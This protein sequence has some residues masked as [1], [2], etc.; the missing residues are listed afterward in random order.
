MLLPLQRWVGAPRW[1]DRTGA[2]LEGSA[3][4]LAT[5]STL[6]DI[7]SR[8]AGWYTAQMRSGSGQQLVVIRMYMRCTAC[9]DA[10]QSR[11]RRGRIPPL[12]VARADSSRRRSA[13]LCLYP[14]CVRPPRSSPCCMGDMQCQFN[15]LPWGGGRRAAIRPQGRTRIRRFPSRSKNADQQRKSEENITT[16]D[17]KKSTANDIHEYVYGPHLH[18]LC[19]VSSRR[20]ST[21]RVASL[22]RTS[23]LAHPS[24]AAAHLRT[25][26]SAP[27]S[28]SSTLSSPPFL[29]LSPC[30]A[31]RRLRTR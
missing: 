20:R 25:S 4:R 27:P 3:A 16:Y 22:H 15:V 21:R 8:E 12:L 17:N 10:R 14:R 23:P 7:C 5:A 29:P 11:G 6:A 19:G 24:S 1:T 31:S 9:R 18:H 28:S 30:R 26:F 2:C 13:A